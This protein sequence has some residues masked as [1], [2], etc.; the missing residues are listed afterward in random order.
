M[1]IDTLSQP[2]EIDQHTLYIGASVG[3]AIGPRD[4]RTVETLIRS[5]DLAL[6]RSKDDGG[7]TFNAYEPQLHTHAEERRV[8]EIALRKALERN[9]F[10]LHYQ[11]VVSA[12]NGRV[13]SF[14]ALLRW[15]NPEL[16]IGVSGQVHSG[17][18]RCAPDR[19]DWRM[20]VAHRVR[21]SRATGLPSSAWP[22]TSRPNS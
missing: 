18:R 2:Y 3:T 8:V 14:E 5:A 22:L 21:R 13:E 17:C 12:E 16:G 4:G 19:A 6:Y 7:G 10:E 1:I 15:N 20:G 9:E 11:P